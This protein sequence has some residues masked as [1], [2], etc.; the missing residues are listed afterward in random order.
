M[1]NIS[2]NVPNE[3]NLED[4]DDPQINTTDFNNFTDLGKNMK[5]LCRLSESLCI[6]NKSHFKNQLK[7]N[8]APDL[9]KE[10]VFEDKMLYYDSFGRTSCFHVVIANRRFIILHPGSVMLISAVANNSV[11][12]LHSRVVKAKYES[13]N[14]SKAAKSLQSNLEPGNDQAKLRI[15]NIN[16]PILSLDSAL[17]LARFLATLSKL[18]KEVTQP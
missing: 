3:Q 4:N 7:L 6:L 10:I 14:Q 5:V 13:R 1:E 12:S 8:L 9:I 17:F 16:G 18:Y 11:L 15:P 2:K